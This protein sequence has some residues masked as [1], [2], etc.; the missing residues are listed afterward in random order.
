MVTIEADIGGGDAI[1][2]RHTPGDPT[3]L[4]RLELPAGAIFKATL[5]NI[6]PG[7]AVSVHYVDA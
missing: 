4:A 7:D 2:Y 6:N 3:S 1:A 5:V